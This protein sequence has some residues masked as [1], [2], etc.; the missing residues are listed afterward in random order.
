MRGLGLALLLGALLIGSSGCKKKRQREPVRLT[1]Q[2]SLATML[3]AGDPG[4]AV[5][6]SKGFYAVENNAWR[7]AAH[8]FSVTLHPPKAAAANGARLVLKFAI[9]DAVFQKVGAMKLTA[10]VNGLDLAPEEYKAA[11]EQT[12]SRDVPGNAL[13]GEAVMVD[14]TVDKFLPPSPGD[15]RELSV[16]VNAVGFEVK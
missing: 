15:P 4:A 6:F 8:A 16:I 7:W 11:G 10:R 5:Q 13:A 2:V 12:Y 1:E 9:P 14:F 3:Q